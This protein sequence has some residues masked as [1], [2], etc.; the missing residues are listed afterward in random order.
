MVILLSWSLEGLGS[1]VLPISLC[2]SGLSELVRGT[3]DPPLRIEAQFLFVHTT[4]LRFILCL[5]LANIAGL[6][7]SPSWQKAIG[8]RLL[9]L[10][11]DSREDF[12]QDNHSQ[13]Q[14]YHSVH[15]NSNVSKILVNQ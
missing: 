11:E 10:N 5:C 7:I 1:I 6:N 14:E 2:E 12:A 13:K 3:S 4:L 15:Q 9:S 8:P